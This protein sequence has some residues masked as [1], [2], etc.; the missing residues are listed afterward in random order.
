MPASGDSRR[1]P[2]QASSAGSYRGAATGEPGEETERRDTGQDER[3]SKAPGGSSTGSRQAATKMSPKSIAA[4]WPM[5][6]PKATEV[7]AGPLGA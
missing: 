5:G 1:P 3:R 2:W 7:E 4:M 6:K